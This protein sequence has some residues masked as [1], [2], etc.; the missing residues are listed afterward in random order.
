MIA[1]EFLKYSYETIK[2]Y[3]ELRQPEE[4][5]NEYVFSDGSFIVFDWLH[6]RHSAF[7]PEGKE[8]K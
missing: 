4:G 3:S 6:G 7:D 8:L 5:A 1:K 2:L